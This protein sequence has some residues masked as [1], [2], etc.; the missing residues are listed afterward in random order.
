MDSS[1]CL[2]SLCPDGN[3]EG[4][5][6]GKIWCQDQ[7]CEPYCP[8]CVLPANY[9][10]FVNTVSLI[11]IVCLLVLLVIVVARWGRTSSLF[12]VPLSRLPCIPSPEY[13]PGGMN[14]V[15]IP[16]SGLFSR[17]VDSSTATGTVKPICWQL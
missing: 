14:E 1:H 2:A 13:E 7:R 8:A 4:C 9:D 10:R 6:D 16:G 11:F 5:K 12:Y 3:C 17:Q 15:S